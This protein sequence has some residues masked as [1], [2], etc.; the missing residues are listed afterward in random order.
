MKKFIPGKLLAIS[1]LPWDPNRNPR[2]KGNFPNALVFYC[3][4]PLLRSLVNTCY[5]VVFVASRTNSSVRVPVRFRTPAPLVTHDDVPEDF[6]RFHLA[7][8]RY[9][10]LLADHDFGYLRHLND[11]EQDEGDIMRRLGGSPMCVPLYQPALLL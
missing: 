7:S 10:H 4:S 8:S 6:R 3:E 11:L 9:V 1:F 5:F 2:N